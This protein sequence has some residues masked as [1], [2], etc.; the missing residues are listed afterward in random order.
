MLEQGQ[1]VPDFNLPD[2]NGDEHSLKD[3]Q[4][5]KVLLYFYPKDMTS[6]CTVEA[7]LFRDNYSKLQDLGVEV[8][9]ISK[10]DVKSH[11]KFA[12]KHD[13]PFTLL[14]DTETEVNQAY[15]VWKE[16]SM[17]GKKYMGTQRDSFLID[18][19]GKLIKHYVKV[20][21]ATHVD[22]VLTDLADL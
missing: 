8:I 12:D 10:D 17:Y 21:P 4:G 20:K 18:E 16:K 15:G 22:E 11:K 9:G 1:P 6:G 13:L 5:K 2:Q 3:Y 19:D 14:A 7:Q